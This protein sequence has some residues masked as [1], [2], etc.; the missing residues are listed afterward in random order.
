MVACFIA[1]VRL[2]NLKSCSIFKP[3]QEEVVDKEEEADVEAEDLAV[4]AGAQV[5][6]EEVAGDRVD[7]AA[8]LVDSVGMVALAALLVILGC[9]ARK[10]VDSLH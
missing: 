6:A 2:N 1:N 8:G 7:P 9:T 10:F 4:T 3:K 5:V